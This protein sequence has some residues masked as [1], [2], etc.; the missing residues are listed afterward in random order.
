MAGPLEGLRVV[1]LGVWVAGPAAGGILADWG[2]DV[3]KIEPPGGDPARTFG[4]MLGIQPQDRH[5]VSP[6][7]QMDNRGKRSVV[8]DLATADGQS[9]ARELLAGADVF[10]TNIRTGALRRI[11][12]DFPAVA[13][14]NPQL[15]YGLITGYG[16]DGP[17]ADRPA[18][19]VA[20]FWARSGLAHL[21]T[22]PGEAPPFQRGG[23]GDHMAG[24]TLAGAVCAAL[25]ARARTGAGQLVSTSLYRQGA[26]TVSFDLNTFLL[27]GHPIAIGQRETMGN[28]CMN[29]YTAADG[30]RFWLVGLQ[31]ERHW[32]ALCAAVERTDWLSDERFATG[33]ARA[34]NAV[35]LIAELDTVFAG[36]TLEEWAEEFSGQP[37]LFWSPINSMEDVIADEQFH[38]SGGIVY[39][40][41]SDGGAVPMVATPAD[42]HGTPAEVRCAAP[43]LG[44]HT[45]EVLA[46]LAQWTNRSM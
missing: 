20:A 2:A 41:D 15:I 21:L 32:P 36:K 30:R 8:L 6:P 46:E 9:S 22:R 29:N 28:P 4:R 37:D 40:P 1:E 14:A 18:Y 16:S 12:L 31:G 27:T 25:V 3:V 34:A 45:E 42:F 19:D 5:H 33:R 11:G 43:E 35:E 7:F 13:A 39:V 26:Y 23:M 24:M 10:L 38:A 44:E 17:D